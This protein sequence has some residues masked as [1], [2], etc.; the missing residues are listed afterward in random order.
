[1]S[2]SEKYDQLAGAQAKNYNST[3]MKNI[4]QIDEGH[5]SKKTA[6]KYRTNFR[7]FLDYI[8]IYDLDVLLDLGKEAIQELVIKYAKSMRD[9]SEKKYSRGTIDNRVSAIL[10]FLDNNDI[11]L[12]RRKIRRYYPPDE[13]LR[14]DRSFR[15]ECVKAKPQFRV[16]KV[17]LEMGKPVNKQLPKYR[18]VIEEVEYVRKLTF[19][20]RMLHHEDIIE[21][22]ETNIDGRPLEL[23]GP[24]IYLFASA[25]LGSKYGS[26]STNEE[27]KKTLLESK[28]LPTLS[29]FLR[30]KGQLAEKTLEGVIYQAL[31]LI[32]SEA[33]EIVPSSDS[34][35]QPFKVTYDRIYYEIKNLTDATDSTNPNEHA[36]YSV[37]Y[38]KITHRQIIDKCKRVFHGNPDRIANSKALLFDKATVNKVGIAYEVIDEIKILHENEG[39]DDNSLC[40]DVLN[41]THNHNTQKNDKTESTFEQDGD[42]IKDSNNEPYEDMKI[43]ELQETR[44]QDTNIIDG[45]D[46]PV[47]G[48]N[49]DSKDDVYTSTALNPVHQYTDPSLRRTSECLRN[50]QEAERTRI[51]KSKSKI[52]DTAAANLSGNG[53][54][55]KD[56]DK[57]L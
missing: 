41:I 4:F 10:Y 32:N 11:E 23:T 50:L 56:N 3:T 14:D 38:G 8:K 45:Q 27:R 18:K 13:S 57:S 12:N 54:L 48:D 36:I 53:L 37:E 6:A 29:E 34:E 5:N 2:Q 51:Q 33:V 7:L 31:K 40:T 9:N 21:E 52:A 20:F 26:A 1:L 16:K 24:Q 46:S 30:R 39:E 55:D 22:V 35:R 47:T 43:E 17:L 44:Y 49:N 25:N 42:N 28:I 15:F 19:G